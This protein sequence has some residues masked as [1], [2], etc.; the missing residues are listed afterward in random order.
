MTDKQKLYEWS[1]EIYRAPNPL[2]LDRVGLHLDREEMKELFELAQ[3]GIW[4]RD[5][6]II[7]LEKIRTSARLLGEMYDDN[8]QTY[9]WAVAD[10]SLAEIPKERTKDEQF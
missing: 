5:C 7:A 3:L 10:G 4:A 1:R 6:G 9:P 2:N 8:S